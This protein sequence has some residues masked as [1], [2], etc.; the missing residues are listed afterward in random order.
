MKLYKSMIMLIF[1]TFPYA[2]K[3]RDGRV[4]LNLEIQK[5]RKAEIQKIQKYKDKNYNCIISGEWE[6]E[7]EAKGEQQIFN[8]NQLP[9]LVRWGGTFSL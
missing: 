7:E 3:W 2:I 1:D 6:R 9:C 4:N 8:Q 5:Y